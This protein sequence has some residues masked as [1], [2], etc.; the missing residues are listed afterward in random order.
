MNQSLEKL[1]AE[2]KQLNIDKK[3]EEHKLEHQESLIDQLLDFKYLYSK[4]TKEQKRA[5]LIQIIDKIIV[6]DNDNFT[7]FFKF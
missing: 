4:G 2:L 1:K 7:I 5:I 6:R 3:L